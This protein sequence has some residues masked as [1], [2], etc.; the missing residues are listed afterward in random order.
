M[1][2]G[3]PAG[4]EHCV[5]IFLH[6]QDKYPGYWQLPLAH[7]ALA[8]LYRAVI[9]PVVYPALQWHSNNCYQ[10]VAMQLHVLAAA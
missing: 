9:A 1:V 4:W 6:D 10:Q 3:V 5:P 8:D 7:P 2:V